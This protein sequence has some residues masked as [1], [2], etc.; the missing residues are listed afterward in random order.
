VHLKRHSWNNGRSASVHAHITMR[1]QADGQDGH[2]G[3]ADGDLAD[4]TRDHMLSRWGA[5]V[6]GDQLLFGGGASFLLDAGAEPGDAHGATEVCANSP[7]L[8]EDVETCKAALNSSTTTLADVLLPGCIIDVCVGGPEAAKAAVGAAETLAERL[9][10]AGPPPAPRPDGWYDG[11]AQRACDEGCGELGL[12]CSEEQLRAHNGDV[13][14]PEK[15]FALVGEVGGNTNAQTCD[16]TWGEADD[17]PNWWAGGC[18]ASIA[19]R[20]PSSFSCAARPRGTRLPKHRLCYCH[21]P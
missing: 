13:D 2:C 3:R 18:H 15:V 9:L 19:S 7:P 4:D 20:S 12:V 5:Q 21:A 1:K 11:G 10:A 16:E 6:P 17:V 14:S 8:P